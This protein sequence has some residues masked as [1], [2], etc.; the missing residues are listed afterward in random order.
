MNYTIK[1]Q[2]SVWTPRTLSTMLTCSTNFWRSK[3]QMLTHWSSSRHVFTNFLNTN[4]RIFSTKYYVLHICFYFLK[5]SS[6]LLFAGDRLEHSIVSPLL[7]M[8]KTEGKNAFFDQQGI[9]FQKKIVDS[10]YENSWNYVVSS[11]IGGR[12]QSYSPACW[13]HFRPLER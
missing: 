11:I 6:F 8:F 3:L 4:Q 5:W 9:C 13:Y 2:E 12:C 7:Q 10:Y 1:L